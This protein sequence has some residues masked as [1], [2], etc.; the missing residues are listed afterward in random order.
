MP[1]VLLAQMFCRQLSAYIIYMIRIRKLG[2][3]F[4]FPRQVSIQKAWSTRYKTAVHTW[5]IAWPNIKWQI[6]NF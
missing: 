6:V 1:I 3:C 2:Y 5:Y 4:N